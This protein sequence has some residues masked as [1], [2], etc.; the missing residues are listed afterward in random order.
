MR[1]LACTAAGLLLAATAGPALAQDVVVEGPGHEISPGTVI[2]PAVG[3]TTGIDSNVF[4][5]DTNPTAAPLIRLFGIFAIASQADKP[6]G[7][8]KLIVDNAADA[9]PDDSKPT[10]VWRLGGRLQLEGYPTGSTAVTRRTNFGGNVMGRV[11]V[12]PDGPVSFSVADRFTRDTRPHN[13][14]SPRQPQPGCQP[15]PGRARLQAGRR[16]HR[17]RNPL[18]EHD[19]RLRGLFGFVRQPNSAPPRRSR[20][21]ADPSDHSPDARSVIRLLRAPWQQRVG[22]VPFKNSSNPLRVQFA[23]ATA[24]SEMTTLKARIGYG[25]GF[26]SALES[27]QNV[28]G[29]A[30]FGYRYSEMGRIS[31][32]YEYDFHDSINANYFRDH[33]L[34][35]KLQQQVGL[36]LLSADASARLRGYRGISPAIGAAS[37]DDV[38]LAAGLTANYLLRDWFAITGDFQAVSDQTNY[39]TTF[40][41]VRR[42]QLHPGRGHRWRHRRVLMVEPLRVAIAGVGYWGIN[43]VRVLAAEPGARVTWLCDADEKRLQRAAPHAPAASTANRLRPCW[44]LQT[45]MPWCLRR[46]P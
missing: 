7:E 19:R 1:L 27:F 29:G 46:R 4:Y 17:S 18:R 14:E 31:F 22:G 39:M 13:F 2:H 30:E 26:Y 43:L 8:Q 5:E 45:S 25:N 6:E 42:P 21:L 34:V 44:R 37:R 10:L 33:A 28:I 38:I 36:I 15:P 9:T 32:S 3:V 41:H 16:T 20:R 35:A 40:R 12:K 24:L 23:I 11:V